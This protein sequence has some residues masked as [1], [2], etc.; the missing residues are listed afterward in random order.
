MIHFVSD[1]SSPIKAH[2]AQ[3][4]QSYPSDHGIQKRPRGRSAQKSRNSEKAKRKKSTE[5][6]ER[7]TRGWCQQPPRRPQEECLKPLPSA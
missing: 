3:Q 4:Q 6:R 2:I 7:V 5:G 1:S